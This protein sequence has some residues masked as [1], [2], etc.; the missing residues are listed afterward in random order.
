MKKLILGSIGA[1]FLLSGLYYRIYEPAKSN[2][3]YEYLGIGTWLA[4]LIYFTVFH[5][6][7]EIISFILGLLVLHAGV[8]LLLED[9]LSNPKLVGAMVFTAGVVIVLGSGLSDYMKKR[10]AKT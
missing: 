9:K 10:K 6:Y 4:G 1:A 2:I 5:R 7:R 3:S 8:I